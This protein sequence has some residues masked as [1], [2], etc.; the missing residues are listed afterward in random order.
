[1]NVTSLPLCKEL[2]ELSGWGYTVERYVEN[3]RDH[4]IGVVHATNVDLSIHNEIAPAYDLGY[5][6][7]KLPH[8]DHTGWDLTISFDGDFVVVGYHDPLNANSWREQI[9]D[10]NIED[11]AARLAIELFKQG[12]LKRE[13]KL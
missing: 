5:L 12:I 4:R 1:M 8:Y 13:D 3:Q 11:A 9:G 10:E 6:L 2:Y 7:R